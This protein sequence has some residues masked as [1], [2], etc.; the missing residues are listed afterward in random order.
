V[1]TASGR[2]RA[3]R[4]GRRAEWIG[5]L[6]LLCKG[7]RILAMRHKTALG[8]IDLVIRKRDLVA[9]VEVKARTDILAAVE[10]VSP[11]A[12]SRIHAASDLWLSKRRDAS[13][14]CLRYD[15]LVVRPWRLPIHM[16]D[17]F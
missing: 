4:L 16:K 9:F 2:R 5:A 3:E 6:C 12:Q 17:A 10:A 15:I 13:A 8:E 7:Y 14:L 11:L 1:S